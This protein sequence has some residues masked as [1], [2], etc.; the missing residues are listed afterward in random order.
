M[1]EAK[2]MAAIRVIV[3]LFGAQGPRIPSDPISIFSN[4]GE[5][6]NKSQAWGLEQ[7][8][9]L[10]INHVVHVA[11]GPYERFRAAPRRIVGIYVFNKHCFASKLTECRWKVRGWE[12]LRQSCASFIGS[13]SAPLDCLV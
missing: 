5:K 13:P 8:C 11:F 4:H 12:V 10:R 2:R 3:R 7:A 6:Q 9:T 1:D